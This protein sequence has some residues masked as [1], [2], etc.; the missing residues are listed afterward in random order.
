MFI[1]NTGEIIEEYFPSLD[2]FMESVALLTDEEEKD[3]TLR[4]KVKLMTIHSAKGLEFDY[5]FLTGL[6]ENLFPSSLSLGSRVELEEERRLFYVAITRAKKALTISHALSR[7]R[8]GSLQFC[9]QSR[10]IN[11]IPTKFINYTQ[12]ASMGRG[13]F[14][15]SSSENPIKNPQ[16]T[17][18]VQ[19][20]KK[21]TAQ[22]A[23]DRKLQII[24]KEATIEQITPSIRVFHEKFGF[25]E[26]KQI[27]GSGQDT[28]AVVAFE[29]VGTKTLLLKFAKLIIPD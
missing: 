24:G 13:I 21:E 14:S 27:D 12:K 4:D 1:E 7:Y 25:G 5:V 18:S 10:F 19:F 16:A 23:A 20:R 8:F 22:I 3:E 29:T 15:S 28:K 17:P 6:E 9:E 11:E 2:R 26:V